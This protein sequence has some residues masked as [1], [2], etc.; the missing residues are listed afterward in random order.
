MA[1]KGRVGEGRFD[2]AK[3]NAKEHMTAVIWT[4]LLGL[5]IV[6]PYRKQHKK[7]LVTRIQSVFLSDPN[8]PGEGKQI[9]SLRENVYINGRATVNT[10]KQASA[11]P[12]N[13][14]HSLDATHMMLTALEC[15]VSS[16]FVS[17][18]GATFILTV[19]LASWYY[20]RIGPRLLLDPCL[21]H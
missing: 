3:S 21:D 4:T 2:I 10:V 9:R 1:K 8:K 5:P 12:P 20:L 7:Q 11:F 19:V 17:V 16:I 13:F 18:G 6:Q 14:V 15:D